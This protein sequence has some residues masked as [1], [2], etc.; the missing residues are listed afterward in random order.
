MALG[1]GTFTM[2]NKIL[3]GAYINFISKEA[4]SPTLSERGIAAMGL[5]LDW[6]PDGEIFRVD[7][8]DVE[9]DAPALFGYAYDHEKLRGLRDLFKNARQGFFYKLNAG[10][11][12]AGNEFAQAKYAG[13]RGNDLRVVVQSSIDYPGEFEVSLY[14][15]MEEKDRQVVASAAQLQ[16]NA[17]VTWN[18]AAALAETASTPLTGG[19]SGG[20]VTAADH[21]AFL[22]KLESCSFH[23]LGAVTT[24]AEINALY[25]AYCRRLREE[26]GK[27]F[28]AVLYR[29]PADYEGVV[30]VKNRVKDAGESAASAVYW[31]TGA[32]AACPVNKSNTNR[33]YDGEF[34][35]DG[36]YS[37]Y[38][39]EEA[40]LAGEFALHKVGDDMRVLGD[41]NSLVTFTKEKGAAFQENKTI[42]VIDQIAID[43]ANLFTGEFM[44]EVPNDEAGRIALWTAITK[45]HK[46]L[47][48][49]RAIENF[50][51]DAVK[52][53]QGEK[54][55]SV[56]VQDAVTVTGTMEQ[57]YMTCVVA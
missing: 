56:V 26:R 53:S 23:A 32:I 13:A 2:Q 6:G 50:D 27:K 35:L 4:A 52:V 15:D 47:E 41:V 29:C 12:T 33:L 9:R 19:A 3:P 20:E 49:I 38:Q 11:A 43:I 40:L 57:L 1:A 28:Q 48:T 39:L 51:Q 25:A 34:T 8:R 22:D 46:A 17:F 54:K 44:G 21:Q 18:K 5:V 24:T 36:D 16:D 42:R 55:K 45:H 37:Q 7:A 31:A 14:L 30:N 10:G